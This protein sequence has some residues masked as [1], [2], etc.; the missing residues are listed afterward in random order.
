MWSS[1]LASGETLSLS[2]DGT[3]PITFTLTD[4]EFVAEGTYTTL[5]YSNSLQSWVNVLNANITGITA[6]IVG[7]SIEITS[8][9]G[10]I[11]RAEVTVINTI[12]NPTSLISKGVISN[13]DLSSQGV[14]SD[15][16]LDRNTA[17]IQLSSALIAGDVLS[18]GTLVTQA[19]IE[20]GLVASGSV[21]PFFRR[22]CLD[23]Y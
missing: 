22:T 20:A 3:A 11:N 19:H 5:S 6:S 21:T 15:Y 10:A 1:T 13:T 2:V 17:Q 14:R 16:I 23:F 7:S 9:L 12:S 18:A 8:N 4:A